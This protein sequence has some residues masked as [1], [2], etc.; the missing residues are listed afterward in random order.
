[1]HN[2]RALKEVFMLNSRFVQLI[3]PN[4]QRA[5]QQILY[6]YMK[7][8][9]CPNKRMY[10]NRIFSYSNTDLSNFQKKKLNI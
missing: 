3:R 1:M 7:F 4:I 5:L 2:T 8:I 6:I 10:L 9:K